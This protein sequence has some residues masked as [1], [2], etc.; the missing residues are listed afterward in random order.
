EAAWNAKVI[1]HAGASEI[2]PWGFSDDKQR[3]VY[4]NEAFFLAEFISVESGKPAGELE[5]SELVIT[6][7]G[8]CGAPVIRYRTGDLVRPSWNHNGPCNFVLLEGGVIGRAD[9]MLI[10]RG[11][12]VFPTSIEQILRGFPEI[13]EFRMTA[14]KQGQMDQFSVEIEDRLHQPERVAKE[15]Q[16]RLGLRIE[17]TSVEIGTLPRF[18]GKGRRFVDQRHGA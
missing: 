8:R 7:L 14:F 17:V 15:L 10:I 12:N 2:G 1:D 6:T 4:V 16:I 18:E 5:L 13:V 3:G 9:D 11:V